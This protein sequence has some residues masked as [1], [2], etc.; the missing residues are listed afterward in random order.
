MI[1]LA[2]TQN[3][4]EFLS[5]TF[6]S[7]GHESKKHGLSKPLNAPRMLSNLRS[8]G[9]SRTLKLQGL[10]LASQMERLDTGCFYVES[11]NSK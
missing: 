1:R 8:M 3:A 11:R 5:S 4:H 10:D 9:L 7:K 2:L 6:R